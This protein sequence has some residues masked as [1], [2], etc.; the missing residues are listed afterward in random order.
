[1]KEN[2]NTIIDSDQKRE[3]RKCAFEKYV[4]HV[5]IATQNDK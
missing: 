1:M 5:F 4:L 3:G 2:L